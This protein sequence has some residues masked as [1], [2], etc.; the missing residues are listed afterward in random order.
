M[1][2][3]EL[4]LLLAGRLWRWGSP[5]LGCMARPR[6]AASSLSATPACCQ[7]GKLQ[8]PREQKHACKACSTCRTEATPTGHQL[9]TS[10]SWPAS[11]MHT[12]ASVLAARLLA[13]DQPP[14]RH[15]SGCLPPACKDSRSSPMSTRAWLLQMFVWQARGVSYAALG[16]ECR[17]CCAPRQ[18]LTSHLPAVLPLALCSRASGTS[19]DTLCT[20]R[21]R[22]HPPR[23]PLWLCLQKPRAAA[24]ACPGRERT[25]A[26]L[27][28]LAA[29]ARLQAA[30]TARPESEVPEGAAARRGTQRGLTGTALAAWQHHV[31]R[32][33]GC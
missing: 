2:S 11:R 6:T 15:A 32:M 3:S 23:R 25:A 31:L 1:L 26:R 30:S 5:C 22:S 4:A 7:S 18:A 21:S 29:S 27:S 24:A 20:A 28:L 9:R 33:T 10:R 8:R 12:P 19:R 16:T 14:V 17:W 13:P